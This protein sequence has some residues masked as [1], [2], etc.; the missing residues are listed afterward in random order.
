MCTSCKGYGTVCAAWVFGRESV[1]TCGTL[2]ADATEVANE[3]AF[4]GVDC[5]TV[6]CPFCALRGL[7]ANDVQ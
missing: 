5:D 6:P 2:T 1:C 4:H 7:I 3:M